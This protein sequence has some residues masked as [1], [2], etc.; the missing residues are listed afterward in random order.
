M[1]ILR[2]AAKQRLFGQ[3]VRNIFHYVGSDASQVSMPAIAAAMR[4][5]WDTNLVAQL[6]DEW[7]LYA[8]E[9]KE[10]DDPA[11]PTIEYSFGAGPLDGGLATGIL[12]TTNALLVSW[13]AFTAPPNRGRTYLAGF[14][15]ASTT[16]GRFV[17]GAVIAA[18]A[19]ANDL[20]VL[21]TT[22]G[23][24]MSMSIV[25]VDPET[26]AYVSSNAIEELSAQAIPATQRRRRIGSGI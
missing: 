11:N 17:N 6:S 25:R 7:Q 22:L 14:T 15:V 26:G 2:I 13:K 18:A 16:D 1:P 4:A 23:L 24:N 10:L 8:V 5:A 3:E 19:W 21:P 20:F 12:P 9:A